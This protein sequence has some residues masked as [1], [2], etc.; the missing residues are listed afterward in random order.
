MKRREFLTGLLVTATGA[1]AQAQQKGK[2]YRLAVVDTFSPAADFTEASELP[3]SRGFLARLR[4]LGFAEGRNLEITRYSGE[5]RSER[6]GGMVAEAVNLKP[7]VIF[8][9]STRLLFM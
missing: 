9:R 5:G 7:D 3:V 8:V 2:V 4:Q 1:S 6:Y